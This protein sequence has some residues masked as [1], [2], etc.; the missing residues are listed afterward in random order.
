LQSAD[1][2]GIYYQ[3]PCQKRAD[4]RFLPYQHTWSGF[5]KGKQATGNNGLS[6]MP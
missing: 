6:Q 1:L 3:R 2:K 5:K 4:M